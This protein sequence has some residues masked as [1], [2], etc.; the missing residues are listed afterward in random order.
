MKSK[1]TSLFLFLFALSISFSFVQ[2]NQPILIKLA[3]QDERDVKNFNGIVAGGPIHVIV[4]LGN[5]E[6][7]RFEGDADAIAT[8]VAEVKGN[9][10]IIRPQTSWMSW[11]R[12]YSNKRITAYVNAKTLTSLTVSGSGSLT[13]NGKV[14]AAELTTALSGSG[15]LSATVD[16][17]SLTAAISGSGSMR[18]L[19]SADNANIRLSGS[20]SFGGKEF[21]T[22]NLSAAISGSGSISASVQ[23]TLNAAIS[24]SG[25][26]NYSGNPQVNTKNSGSGKV[27][28]M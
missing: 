17:N 28:K 20:G 11:E 12:K 24:G 10:L 22:L 27:R 13:V 4:S 26:V 25:S 16:V 15:S 2:A 14:N 6:G 18:L 8:L 3:K 19:G 7:L 23:K 5:S 9:I 21:S 1:I